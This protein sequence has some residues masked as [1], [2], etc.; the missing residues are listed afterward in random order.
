M[1]LTP[2]VLAT[3]SCRARSIWHEQSQPQHRMAQTRNSVIPL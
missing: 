1:G 2:S 3:F